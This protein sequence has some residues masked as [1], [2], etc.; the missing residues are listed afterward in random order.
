MAHANAGRVQLATDAA[1]YL[2]DGTI[3]AFTRKVH[4]VDGHPVAITA[5]GDTSLTPHWID[6]VDALVK[7]AGFDVAMAM[8]GDSLPHLREEYE[9]L[10]VELCIAGIGA[11]GPGVYTLRTREE[12]GEDVEP[13]KLHR[14]ASTVVCGVDASAWHQSIIDSRRF[15]LFAVEI[16]NQA[17]RKQASGTAD[18]RRHA[19]I[20]GH[21]DVTTIDARGVR[22]ETVHRWPED[23]IDS[24]I[25]PYR[26]TNVAPMVAPAGNRAQR[27]A[28][29]AARKG[30]AA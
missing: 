30:R 5:R 16:A 23:K 8:L 10:D 26:G 21:L 27:R 2:A 19:S 22:T 28:E 4:V 25:D 9:G 6:R 13:F 1:S 11:A 12:P 18:G 14:S 3:V 7:Q 17:R 24:T 15:D 29:K 20:G